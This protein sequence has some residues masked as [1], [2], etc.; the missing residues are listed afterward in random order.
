MCRNRNYWYL[1]LLK[2]HL[3][4]RTHIKLSLSALHEE[5]GF[6]VQRFYVYTCTR[7]ALSCSVL[8][9]DI[10]RCTITVKIP[11]SE[12]WAK[13]EPN[14]MHV[15]SKLT[16]EID[17]GISPE[18]VIINGYRI[19]QLSIWVCC[20]IPEFKH[21]LNTIT[22]KSLAT[23]FTCKGKKEMYKLNLF[24]PLFLPNTGQ[25]CNSSL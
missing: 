20:L 12:T 23:F 5:G 4:S 22:H 24:S 1:N 9:I 8:Y 13:S 6:T 2:Q 14:L 7:N 15:F 16:Q 21:R 25:Q 18:G 11:Y 10:I 17:L 3:D 19:K